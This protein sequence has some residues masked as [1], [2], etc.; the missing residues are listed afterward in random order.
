MAAAPIIS[1]DPAQ[2]LEFYESVIDGT[3]GTS[4]ATMTLTNLTDGQAAFKIKT[5]RPRKYCVK[6]NWGRLGPRETKVVK[7]ILQS[8]LDEGEEKSKHKFLVESMATSAEVDDDALQ[9]ALKE[10]KKDLIDTRLKCKWLSGPK[11]ASPS[12]S[13]TP[14]TTTAAAT[15]P[16]TPAGAGA[17]AKSASMPSVNSGATTET[18]PAAAAAPASASKAAT[19][20]GASQRKPFSERRDDGGNKTPAT[21]RS[22]TSV[23]TVTAKPVKAD[24]TSSVF[25]LAVVFVLG[26]IFG[27]F[28]L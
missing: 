12:P 8:P 23:K 10:N 9:K 5:T 6:P 11:P 3:S 18:A 19:P 21:S 20:L 26:A 25:L 7:V 14:A 28:V 17:G 24:A 27:K 15:A 22:T 16:A 4:E 13:T 2:Y 1:V